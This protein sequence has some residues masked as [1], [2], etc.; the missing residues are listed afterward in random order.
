ME[1]PHGVVGTVLIEPDLVSDSTGPL[2]IFRRRVADVDGVEVRAGLTVAP[3]ACADRQLPNMSFTIDPVSTSDDLLGRL[4]SGGAVSELM[5]LTTGGEAGVAHRIY[6]RSEQRL[7]RASRVTLSDDVDDLGL[8]RLHLDWRIDQ[9]DLLDAVTGVGLIASAFADLG[10]ALVRNP[11]TEE[12]LLGLT[13]G[14]HHLGGARMHEDA[15][16]GVVDPDLR[17]HGS[18]NLFVCSSA[19]FPAGG[20]SNPTMTVV[21]LAHRLA[22]VVSA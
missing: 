18:D 20:F 9:Q 21:A 6:M 1:H 8:R 22:G 17:V 5:R 15:S 13:G 12:P 19:V 4:A 10:L 14:A 2:A 11:G 3:Q 7:K 16:Q